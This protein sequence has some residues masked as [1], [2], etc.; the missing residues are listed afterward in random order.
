MRL[1]AAFLFLTGTSM[2]AGAEEYF[3]DTGTASAQSVA[4]LERT[5]SGSLTFNNQASHSIFN[6]AGESE[7]PTAEFLSFQ[8]TQKIEGEDRRDELRVSNSPSDAGNAGYDGWQLILTP[9]GFVPMMDGEIT[10]GDIEADINLHSEEIK[11]S[12]KYID[13]AAAF[14]V[15]LRKGK[16]GIFTEAMFFNVQ[17]DVGAEVE[18][19]VF[20]RGVIGRILERRGIDARLEVDGD[21]DIE[22]T[23]GIAELGFAYRVLNTPFKLG[24]R[25]HHAIVDLIAGGRYWYFNSEVNGDI[26]AEVTAGPISRSRSV[27]IS[28]ERTRDWID[29]FIG[30]RAFV[31]LTDR[32]DLILRGDV[33]GFGINSDFA[34][35][36][37]AWLEYFFTERFSAYG[38]YQG[39]GV[40]Y[41]TGNGSDRFELDAVVH[42]P[43]FGIA[44]R[45]VGPRGVKSDD[46]A[47]VQRKREHDRKLDTKERSLASSGV[48]P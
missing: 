20:R 25:E 10:I 18:M 34:W 22:Y 37:T 38:G 46:L 12:A 21:A 8:L 13:W 31:S 11:D 33:G 3:L 2:F 27:N 16:W 41:S 30:A 14:Y 17:S 19:D 26:D 39:M 29:P 5:L 6:F 44:Y 24:K 23:Q 48:T 43:V 9:N 1:V 40:D 28:E 7:V 47:A 4:I 35:R 32:L 36:V 45:F 42:G 15:E